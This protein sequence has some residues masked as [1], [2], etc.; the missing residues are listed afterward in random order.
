MSGA[1]RP[2][3]A[4]AV[5]FN[6]G[7]VSEAVAAAIPDRDAIVY[8]DR[9]ITHA[10]LNERTRRLANHLLGAGLVVRAERADLQPWES[11]QA[12]LAVYLQN[13]N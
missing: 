6:L 11:G 10:L 7:D 3:Y 12:H 13:G 2:R 9:H 8:R 1:R 5:D 4:P